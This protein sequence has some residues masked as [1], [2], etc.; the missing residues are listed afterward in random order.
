MAVC[1]L[2]RH[3]RIFSYIFDTTKFHKY[4]IILNR[5]K[6]RKVATKNTQYLINNI[7]CLSILN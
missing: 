4:F 7:G 1:T 5:S 6:L 3:N 2:L